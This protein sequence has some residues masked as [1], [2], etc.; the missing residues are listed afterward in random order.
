MCIILIVFVKYVIDNHRNERKELT[1]R[2]AVLI[3]ELTEVVSNNTTMISKINDK[4][5]IQREIELSK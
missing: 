2:Y 3:E 4:I 1:E 5:D